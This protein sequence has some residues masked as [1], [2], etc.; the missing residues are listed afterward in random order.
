MPVV[1]AAPGCD[2]DPVREAP[3]AGEGVHRLAGL[4]DQ[5]G[6]AAGGVHGQADQQEK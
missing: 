3:V 6:R 4:D 1:A 5:E 2:P